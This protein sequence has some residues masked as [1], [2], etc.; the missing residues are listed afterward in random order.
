MYIY[1]TYYIIFY[2][3]ILHKILVCTLNDHK[4]IKAKLGKM[5]NILY[6]IFIEAS[7]KF[8]PCHQPILLR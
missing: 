1:Y 3:E 5:R 6:D 8:L 2:R 4:R 7:N